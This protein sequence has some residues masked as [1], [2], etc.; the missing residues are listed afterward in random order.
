MATKKDAA[1]D[2]MAS[3]PYSPAGGFPIYGMGPIASPISNSTNGSGLTKGMMNP[4]GGM[5]GMGGLDLDNF[6]K[7]HG[8]ATGTG[9]SGS[10][11]NLDNF[12][13]M[14]GGASGGFTGGASPDLY[15]SAFL[16]DS[17]G[18]GSL[19]KT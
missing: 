2:S 18:L 16:G 5:S 13:K 7:M 6:M 14:H 19:T 12:M 15:M 8:G 10:G 3:F 1:I 4:M 9:M 11:M 17:Y